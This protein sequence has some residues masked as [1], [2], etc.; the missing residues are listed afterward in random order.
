[1]AAVWRGLEVC[2]RHQASNTPECT[3]ATVAAG[4]PGRCLASIPVDAATRELLRF[5][6][7]VVDACGRTVAVDDNGGRLYI[8]TAAQ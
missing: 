7:A 3:R 1:M 2:V 5:S 6:I 4:R 8:V